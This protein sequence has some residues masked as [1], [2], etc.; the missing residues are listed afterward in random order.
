LALDEC[1]LQQLERLRLVSCNHAHN[2]LTTITTAT[3][4]MTTPIA[5]ARTEQGLETYVVVS[6]GLGHSRRA[7]ARRGGGIR[8]YYAGT[9]EARDGLRRGRDLRQKVRVVVH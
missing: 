7:V 3:T 8:R 4:T 1:F 5:T 2:C 9:G 6:R